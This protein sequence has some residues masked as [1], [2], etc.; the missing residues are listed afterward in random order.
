MRAFLR[1]IGIVSG[2]DAAEMV[3]TIAALLLTV[4]GAVGGLVFVAAWMGAL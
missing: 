1:E 2:W 3:A 4:L